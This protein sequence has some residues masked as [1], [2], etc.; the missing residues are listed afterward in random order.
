[1]E[2]DKQFGS[3]W[4]NCIMTTALQGQDKS[5]KLAKRHMAIVLCTFYDVSSNKKNL[6]LN[7]LHTHGYLIPYW[8][9]PMYLR[10]TND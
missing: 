7:P 9:Q 6:F 2:N 10:V 5:L 1:M 8:G 3:I 4:S